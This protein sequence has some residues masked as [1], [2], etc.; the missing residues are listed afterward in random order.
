[1]DLDDFRSVL[2]TAG[3]DVWMFIDTAI[4]VAS[5][6]YHNELKRRRD[7][8]VQRLYEATSAPGRCRN[9]EAIRLKS[10]GHEI[11]AP[12]EKQSSP[13]LKR[14]ASPVTPHS[15]GQDDGDLDPYGGLFDDEEKKIQEIKEQLEDQDQPE[16]YVVE[17]LQ[18][19]ADMD[20]TFQA[21]KETDIGRHVNR[22]RKHPS[23]DVRRLV[24]LL[25]RKWKEIVDE[26]VK[27]NQ[28]GDIASVVANGDS[29]MQR[30]AQNGHNQIPDFASS[31][32]PHYWSSGSDRNYSEAEPKPKTVP[33]RAPPKPANPVPMPA[34]A[35]Q[36]RKR[37]EGDSNFEAD[38]LASARRRL[39]ENYKEA[40]NAKRQ[41]TIQ[42][43]D[44]HEIPRPKNAFF[45]KNKGGG[46][47]FQGRHR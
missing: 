11:R 10:N 44:L 41:R 36:N 1:M 37:E 29:P 47:G 30:N 5:I 6:D 31:P 18:N 43:M 25:V 8:I 4:D 19:L 40:E 20:I 15:I 32:N 46:G 12:I 3:V 33:R 27:V 17:L 34:S 7:G 42:V 9:C 35:P 23:N 13:E 22:L 38:R 39:Q 21:L 26:W 2:E 45:A 24:K 28:P 14:D 16:D